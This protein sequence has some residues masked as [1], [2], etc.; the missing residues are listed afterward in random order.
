[1]TRILI[2]TPAT[3]T[4]SWYQG[5]T[6]A[7]PGSVTVTVTRDDGTTLTSGS[8]TLTGAG[9]RSFNLA[10]VTQLDK[11]TATWTS[12]TLGTLTST[13]EVVGGF[14]FSTVQMRKRLPD[15]TTYPSADI[16]DAR[17]WAESEIEN[18]CGVAFVPR[19]ESEVLNGSGSQRLEPKWPRVRTLRSAS[20]DGV[21]LAA[22]DLA[23]IVIEY[24]RFF[25][26]P[27]YYW[28]PWP[29]NTIIRYEHGMSSPPPAIT[30]AALDLAQYK[31]VGDAGQSGID[32][33]A[34]RLITDDGTITLG[35]AGVSGRFGIPSVDAALD[36]WSELAVF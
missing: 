22:G 21:P 25:T 8:A 15:T 19:Y 26:R 31:L 16:V 1:M 32:P 28:R 12:A 2:N 36:A 7:D 6:I 34:E 11:L 5:D 30:M 4:Q 13:I 23:G 29:A 33:R 24:E 3:I 9:P 27:Y 18:Y 10:A 17:T 14:L 20:V 35:M